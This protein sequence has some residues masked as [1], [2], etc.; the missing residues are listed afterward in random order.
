MGFFSRLFRQQ[1]SSKNWSDH[2]LIAERDGVS[3]LR[4]GNTLFVCDTTGE[5]LAEQDLF[6]VEQSKV[7]TLSERL[8]RHYAVSAD[9]SKGVD[10]TVQAD[11][12]RNAVVEISRYGFLVVLNDDS[13]SG[14]FEN[15]SLSGSLTFDDK[16]LI[17]FAGVYEIP[18]GV[19][20]IL[21]ESGYDTEYCTPDSFDL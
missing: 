2:E 21:N 4:K 5:V 8:I 19:I 7:I 17:D 14:T 20:K 18:D 12:Q 10:F 3:I 9:P 1:A 15:D 16:C 6:N 13:A 11:D